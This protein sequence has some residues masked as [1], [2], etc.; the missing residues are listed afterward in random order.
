MKRWQK[1]V[2]AVLALGVLLSASGWAVRRSPALKEVVRTVLQATGLE[3]VVMPLL[4]KMGLV[5]PPLPEYCLP[6][7]PADRVSARRL[8]VTALQEALDRGDFQQAA[9]LNG[10]L[11]QEA[12]QRAYRALKAWEPMRDP[13][14][15]LV[16]FATHPRTARWEPEHAG[17]DLYSFLL[18]AS[19]LLDPENEPL[20]LKAMQIEREICGP[21]PC[22]IRFG[23]AQMV[24]RDLPEVTFGASEFAKDGLLA[25]TERLGPGPWLVRMEEV[26]DALIDGASVQTGLGPICSNQTEVNGE[27]LQVLSRL[28]WMTGEERYLEMA[29]RIGEVYLFD[30]LPHSRYL[31]PAAWDFEAR[32]PLHNEIR[33][34]DHGSEIIPG[35]VELYLLEKE[36]GRSQAARYREP[37]QRMLEAVLANG[38]AEDGLWYSIVDLE[39]GRPTERG[40]V[41]TWGYILNAY[42]TFDLA[43][44]SDTYAAEIER[45]MRTVATYRSFPW[46]GPLQ[47]GYA[48][49]I[50]SMLYLLPW[51]D[52]P[53]AHRWV[54]DEIE[55]MFGKQLSS[56]FV[57]GW[58]LDGN[59][60]R[61]AL[62]YAAYKTQGVASWPWRWD[63]RVGSAYDREGGVLY[64]CVGA[65]S[66]WE[67]LLR[68]DLPRHRLFWNMPFEYPRL[69]GTP[70]WFVVEPEGIYRV[71]DFDTGES[72]LYSGQALADGVPVSLG[73]E[74][75][76]SL[77]LMVTEQ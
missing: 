46:E 73:G 18:L 32:R 20:W 34:R 58:Y 19:H 5:T 66:A 26:M 72:S 10:I 57:E 24:E 36:F 50:E 21:M 45:V 9:Q 2:V 14:T 23:P 68:F 30:V 60:I 29:E 64:V 67:G 31:P 38:R 56:G 33:F 15:G 65:E 3:T 61:T 55:V 53:E 63:V 70:E 51:F 40:V 54:D 6:I 48:D 13:G 22:M 12:Y 71:V 62:L 43:E 52:I 77:R 1:A 35:L 59:F 8:V 74:G 76:M 47:D 69:N 17:A 7:L 11:A 41:D 42:Q 44:G 49:T 27:M 39:T 75:G 37:L 25:L 4:Q 16:P 28:Y